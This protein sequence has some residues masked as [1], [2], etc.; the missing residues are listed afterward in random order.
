MYYGVCLVVITANIGL[1]VY[2]LNLSF[3]GQRGHKMSRLIK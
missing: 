1:S 3:G 2:V